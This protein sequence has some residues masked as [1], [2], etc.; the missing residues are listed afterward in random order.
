VDQ[1]QVAFVPDAFGD[2]SR[3][4]VRGVG[5]VRI[6]G[7]EGVAEHV[8]AESPCGHPFSGLSGCKHLFGKPAAVDAE[9]RLCDRQQESA[10]ELLAPDWTDETCLAFEQEVPYGDFHVAVEHGAQA[11][12][13][14][15]RIEARGIVIETQCL[16]RQSLC[17]VGVTT[18]EQRVMSER[19]ARPTC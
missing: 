11:E 14:M 2:R 12:N 13:A 7:L 4:A 19:S 1:P 15:S 5:G 3:C 6:F 9:I 16:V 8:V 18:V 17:Q 10:V